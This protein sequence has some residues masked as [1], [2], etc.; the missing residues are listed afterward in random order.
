MLGG[1]SAPLVFVINLLPSPL[2]TQLKV[3]SW[4]HLEI[5]AIYSVVEEKGYLLLFGMGVN[6]R[7]EKRWGISLGIKNGS[8]FCSIEIERRRMLDI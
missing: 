6:F 4:L 8:H 3:G 2:V 5:P 1:E 7:H